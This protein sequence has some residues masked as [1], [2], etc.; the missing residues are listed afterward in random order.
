[1]EGVTTTVSMLA[2]M[3]A[4]PKSPMTACAAD[5]QEVIFYFN[6]KNILKLKDSGVVD[7]ILGDEG[8]TMNIQFSR[9]PCSHGHIPA[10]NHAPHGCGNGYVLG[11]PGERRGRQGHESQ[12]QHPRQAT[13][14]GEGPNGAGEDEQGHNTNTGIEECA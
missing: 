1:M 3:V 8:I 11:L 5:M 2:T 13:R 4:Q 14:E 10:G 12:V 7:I 6:K 9:S